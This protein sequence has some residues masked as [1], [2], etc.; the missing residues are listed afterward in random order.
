MFVLNPFRPDVRVYKEA[1]TL[2][3]AG[4]NV[5]IIALR[6]EGRPSQ[7]TLDNGIRVYRIQLHGRVV[8]KPTDT[9][10]D[11]GGPRRRQRVF[12]SFQ[13]LSSSLLT[14]WRTLRR[15]NPAKVW[16]HLFQRL[17]RNSRHILERTSFDVL[18]AHD[19]NTL[20]LAASVARA[21]GAQLVYDAHEL[22]TEVS[23]L[24]ER[25]KRFWINEEEKYI[26]HADRIIT[27]CTSI[28][29]ELQQRYNIPVPVVLHNCPPLQTGLRNDEWIR[30]ALCI[31]KET[32]IALYQ[33]GFSA[34][35]GLS[36]LIEAAASFDQAA[37][38]FMGW[39]PLETQL[40][41]EVQERRLADKVFFL[42]PVAQNDLLAW[43]ASADLGIIP[44]QN[45]GLNNYYSCPNKLFEYM[46]G[47]LGIAGSNFP[48][49]RRFI[50]GED[51]G[52]T[53][54]PTNPHSISDAANR[55]FSQPDR[56]DTLKKN[57]REARQ[58]WHW[59]RQ[60]EKLLGIY[61]ALESSPHCVNEV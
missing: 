24:N 55:I 48:E 13:P 40:R 59:G 8:D 17:L 51:I 22:Y 39:G 46:H 3:E 44:Y 25:E 52:T 50:L 35:R 5:T 53:F 34:N 28:A 41:N 14:V 6:A 32:P 47:G 56:L 11:K 16:D 21:H 30:Q 38:V 15:R 61:E 10:S 23:L 7:E 2:Q 37:L 1:V 20:R 58:R 49:L 19:L 26:H 54:D 43:T 27:V 33:G 60:A 12:R 31:E 42:P 36:T 9:K 57:A 45:I 29:E 18:H 4:H